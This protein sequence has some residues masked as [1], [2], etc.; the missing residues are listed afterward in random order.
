M[1]T[2]FQSIFAHA[3]PDN[4]QFLEDI[5][6]GLPAQREY[7]LTSG[8]SVGDLLFRFQPGPSVTRF[9]F[10]SSLNVK[11]LSWHTIEGTIPTTP[12][13]PLLANDRLE[14]LYGSKVNNHIFIFLDEALSTDDY[15]RVTVG[16]G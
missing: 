4:S 13:F 7:Q 3:N 14:I 6:N 9:S 12:R 5:V 8:F 11:Y 1:P 15:F 16:Y 10:V 2:Y